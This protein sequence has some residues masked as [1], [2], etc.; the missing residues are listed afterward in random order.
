MVKNGTKKVLKDEYG[1]LVLRTLLDMTV[2]T[3]IILALPGLPP[4]TGPNLK[5]FH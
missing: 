4:Y 5:F 1:A 2:V 3:L